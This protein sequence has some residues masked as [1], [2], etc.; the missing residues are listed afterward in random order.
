MPTSGTFPTSLAIPEVPSLFGT[1][2]H[3][4]VAVLEID[5]VG[6]ITALTSTNV[7]QLVVGV[8]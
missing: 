2:L 6:A 1:V 3:H 5:A 4:Q 8:F 7:L